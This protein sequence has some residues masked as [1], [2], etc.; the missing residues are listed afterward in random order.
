MRI[1]ALYDVHGMPIPLA[2]VLD[3]LRTEHMDAIV[4]GGDV[5]MGPRPRETLELVRS[6]EAQFV[7]GNCAR[8]PSD[9]VRAH[10]DE[11]IVEWAR[12][13]PLTV[14]LDGALYCHATPHSDDPILADASPDERFEAALD[15]VDARLVV[16]GHTHMQF[17]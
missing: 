1:A 7:R 2:A 3:E 17:R 9:W 12:A 13:W 5:F 8:E 14:E 10:L 16:A 4:F 11:Q 15:G 6:V